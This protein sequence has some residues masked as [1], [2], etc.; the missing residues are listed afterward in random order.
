MSGRQSKCFASLIGTPW[1]RRR[2]LTKESKRSS[3]V[4]RISLAH[5][6]A[7]TRRESRAV[8][9][10][11]LNGLA[12]I[13]STGPGRVNSKASW[14]TFVFFTP[15]E[16]TRP[17]IVTDSKVL[18]M[19]FSRRLNRPIVRRSPRIPSMT[20]PRRTRRSTIFLVDLTRMNPRGSKNL[21]PGRS[22]QS[23]P[24]PP[25]TLDGSR[26]PSPST[27]ATT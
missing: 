3:R 14:I 9:L 25:S 2:P 17:E 20:S 13:R 7:T 1:P 24:P 15:R 23:D 4:T 5:P 16:S 26:S 19:R 6:R 18:Q 12:I 11:R 10:T 21:Q 8:L 27:V 22:W